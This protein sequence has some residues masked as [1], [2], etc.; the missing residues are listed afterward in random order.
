MV[1]GVQLSRARAVGGKLIGLISGG[2]LSLLLY[3]MDSPVMW[4][5]GPQHRMVGGRLAWGGE[6]LWRSEVGVA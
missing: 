4:V 3:S 6:G 1:V 2:L 5:A